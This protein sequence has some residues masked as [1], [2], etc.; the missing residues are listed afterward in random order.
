MRD[1]FTCRL[2]GGYWREKLKYARIFTPSLAAKYGRLHR[3]IWPTR[4]SLEFAAHSLRKLASVQ[5]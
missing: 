3:E 2:W 5:Q 1:K 4:V